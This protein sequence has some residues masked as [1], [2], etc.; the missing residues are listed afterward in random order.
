MD[1]YSDMEDEED[2]GGGETFQFGTEMADSSSQAL[3]HEVADASGGTSAAPFQFSSELVESARGGTNLSDG[4]VN[5]HHPQSGQVVQPAVEN[6]GPK[7]QT[8]QH[9]GGQEATDAKEAKEPPP[10]GGTSQDYLALAKM[11]SMQTPYSLP[12]V[13]AG[14]ATERPLCVLCNKKVA[15]SVLFPCEHVCLCDPCNKKERFCSND[16]PLIAAGG[17]CSCPLCASVIRKILPYEDGTKEVEKYWKWVHEVNP[18]LPP[19]FMKNW[20]HSAAVI[21]KVWIDDSKQSG[22][23]RAC[24]LM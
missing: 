1:Y 10:P 21:Q 11:H 24:V 2:S 9:I 23:S 12:R 15:Q 5:E 14:S 8:R 22:G 4:L 7:S 3:V 19:G 13:A 16:D 17:C 20:R 18:N 6:N